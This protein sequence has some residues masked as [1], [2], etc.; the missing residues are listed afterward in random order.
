MKQRHCKNST[1]P[2]SLFF[3]FIFAR[4]KVDMLGSLDG[5]HQFLVI[6]M[7]CKKGALQHNNAMARDIATENGKRGIYAT[8]NIIIRKLSTKLQRGLQLF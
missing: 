1:C 6:A 7:T 3:V 4:E 2:V 8:T 5:N